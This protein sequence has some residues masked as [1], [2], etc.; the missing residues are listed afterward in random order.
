MRT[1]YLAKENHKSFIPPV[2]DTLQ[3][4]EDITLGKSPAS[5]PQDYHKQFDGP[6]LPQRDRKILPQPPSQLEVS[7]RT[8]Q[9]LLQHIAEDRREKEHLAS[10][11]NA[12]NNRTRIMHLIADENKKRLWKLLRKFFTEK[13]LLNVNL[14]ELYD[15]IDKGFT[16]ED[17]QDRSTPPLPIREPTTDLLHLK[18][19]KLLDESEA[20]S[21]TEKPT[22]GN[23]LSRV[24]PVATPHIP[25][26]A[27]PH[28]TIPEGKSDA[29]EDE[30]N[31]ITSEEE[32]TSDS[33]SGD[34]TD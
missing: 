26:S 14:Q 24:P 34:A 10:E 2:R 21:P 15:Y 23:V 28:T 13:Q 22:E 19:R 18:L 30:D 27:Q 11:L 4:M 33:S 32:V 25:S 8:Q 3:V 16:V 1:V 29:A 9:L 31:P 5:S 6:R 7:L 12:L 20:T 17:F